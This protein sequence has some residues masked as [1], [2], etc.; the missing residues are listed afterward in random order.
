VFFGGA[1]GSLKTDSVLGDWLDHSATYGEH[2]AGLMVR[3]SREELS[4]TIERARQIYTPLGFKFAG[5]QCHSPDGSHLT[6]AYLDRDSDA[7]RYQGWSLTRV[8]VEE[9]GNFPAEAPIQKLMATLRS[10]QGVSVGFRATGSPGGPGHHWVKARYIDP[11][12]K[13]WEVQHY[14][15][16]NPFDGQ[17]V[18]KDRVFIPGKITDHD[19]LGPEYIANLQMAG[20]ESLVRAWLLG[21]WDVIEGAFFDVWSQNMVI[22]PVA[23]PDCLIPGFDGAIFSAQWKEALWDRYATAAP[24]PRT[25]SER[26]Y[27]DRKLRPRR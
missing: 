16:T 12:P 21:D 18:T 6:F 2:A 24:R 14:D 8:Y 27:S 23:L 15:Y 20:S 10:A 13:G 5:H 4:E 9:I 22:R 3:R 25:R 26:Q 7:D 1:R 17:V 19:L 11:A